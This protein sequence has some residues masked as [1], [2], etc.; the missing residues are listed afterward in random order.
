MGVFKISLHEKDTLFGFTR[1]SGSKF[2]SGSRIERTWP[3]PP[4]TTEGWTQG[5]QI[6][7]PRT[8][9]GARGLMSMDIGAGIEWYPAPQL[10]EVVVFTVWWQTP[11]APDG[12]PL[13]PGGAV[14]GRVIERRTG[15]NV[16]VMAHRMHGDAE[17]M[18][19]CEITLADQTNQLVYDDAPGRPKGSLIRVHTQ[20]DA[21][22]PQVTDLPVPYRVRN[23]ST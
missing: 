22:Q 13:E 10:G 9:L 4:E 19:M 18:R 6:M 7:V 15:G 2:E 5:P 3:R 8:S 16:W 21:P 14:M 12:A 11:G 1:E 23:A 20:Q 17:Y